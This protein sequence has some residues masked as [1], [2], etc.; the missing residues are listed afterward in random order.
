M[1]PTSKQ[2]NL[3]RNVRVQPPQRHYEEDDDLTE[4]PQYEDGPQSF[5]QAQSDYLDDAMDGF[6]ESRYPRNNGNMFLPSHTAGMGVDLCLVEGV[7]TNEFEGDPDPQP[8]YSG[9]KKNQRNVRRGGAAT[10]TKKTGA[11]AAANSA[12]AAQQAQ[13]RKQQ[14]QL[15]QFMKHTAALNG[16]AADFKPTAAPSDWSRPPAQNSM[17]NAPAITW[18]PP[19]NAQWAYEP[20]KAEVATAP[21][22]LAENTFA[23]KKADETMGFQHVSIGDPDALHKFSVTVSRKFSLTEMK[24]SVGQKTANV[25]KIPIDAA[26]FDTQ[27]PATWDA[28]VGAYKPVDLTKGLLHS[29]VVTGYQNDHCKNLVL[30]CDGFVVSHSQLTQDGKRAPHVAF[31]ETT[32]FKRQPIYSGEKAIGNKQ[33][34]AKFGQ[35]DPHSLTSDLQ[36]VPGAKKGLEPEVVVTRD[37]PLIDIIMKN[38]N[39]PEHARVKADLASG[40]DRL[41]IRKSGAMAVLSAL[42]EQVLS[43]FNFTNMTSLNMTVRPVDGLAADDLSGTKYAFASDEIKKNVVQTPGDATWTLEFYTYFPRARRDGDPDYTW[44]SVPK[45]LR[46]DAV[47]KA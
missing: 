33:L 22:A 5:L 27:K 32:S 7:P 41:L 13:N 20:R 14:L 29:V 40:N 28:Q 44:E 4:E 17:W 15:N 19:A 9:A 26:V 30:D 3:G 43:K 47:N 12:A 21:T 11:N 8:E 6:G 35:I 34:L 36:V 38:E 37:H 46:F 31:K 39:N 23:P 10:R 2:K 1:P 45:E 24:S 25:I 18:A 42:D 16:G